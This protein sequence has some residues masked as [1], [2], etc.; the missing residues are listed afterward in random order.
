M[1]DSPCDVVAH[2]HVTSRC[3]LH[4]HLEHHALHSMHIMQICLTIESELE[5]DGAKAPVGH[6]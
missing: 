5:P 6:V 4:G 3:R 2:W 1:T